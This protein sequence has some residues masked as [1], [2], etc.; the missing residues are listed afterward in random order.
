MT[1]AVKE[2]KK[3]Q[4]RRL[5]KITWQVQHVHSE[6]TVYRLKIASSVSKHLNIQKIQTL[7]SVSCDTNSIKWKFYTE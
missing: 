1:Q 6:Y 4:L 5:N 2:N 7:I 3:K